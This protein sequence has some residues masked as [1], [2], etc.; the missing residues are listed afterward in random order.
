MAGFERIWWLPGGRFML[1]VI[2]ALAVVVSVVKWLWR[3]VAG[4]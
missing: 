1:W 2:L 3:L 4:Q